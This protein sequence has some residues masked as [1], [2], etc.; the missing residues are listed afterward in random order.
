MYEER[1]A[2][3]CREVSYH[4]HVGRRR[5]DRYEGGRRLGAQKVPRRACIKTGVLCVQL[6]EVHETVHGSVRADEVADAN[7]RFLLQRLVAVGT[8][9]DLRNRRALGGAVQ[10]HLSVR[11]DAY[12]GRHFDEHREL[13]DDVH[14]NGGLGLIRVSSG[15]ALVDAGI[16]G[17]NRVHQ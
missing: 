13:R 11:I 5:F 4:L 1:A 16:A 17:L 14:L 8:P 12:V 2:S 3:E 15:G 10:R 7:V 9:E 6:G